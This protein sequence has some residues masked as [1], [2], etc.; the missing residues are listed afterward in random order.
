MVDSLRTFQSFSLRQMINERASYLEFGSD[1]SATAKPS[2]LF[3]DLE[4][5]LRSSVMW[6]Q[7]KGYES[8][9]GN[10]AS[11]ASLKA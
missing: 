5:C 1:I 9:F 7:W 10:A 3:E 4:K 2:S 6:K 11:K 8:G